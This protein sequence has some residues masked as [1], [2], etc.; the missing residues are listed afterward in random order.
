MPRF[1]TSGCSCDQRKPSAQRWMAW[2]VSCF[3]HSRASSF[4]R[5]VSARGPASAGAAA[6]A[7]TTG[8]G[9]GAAATG[10]G[11]AAAGFAAGA[12]SAAGFAAGAVS[13]A[14]LAAAV[15]SAAGF[16]AGVASAAFAASGALPAAA[17]SAGLAGGAS[18]CEAG[19]AAGGLALITIG[20]GG[21]GPMNM[22]QA[23][24]PATPSTAIPAAAMPAFF[25][26]RLIAIAVS[27]IVVLLNRLSGFQDT[28]KPPYAAL[29]SR[30]AAPSPCVRR[31]R[32][33]APRSA[34]VCP[35][36]LPAHRAVPCRKDGQYR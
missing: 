10:A 12:A 2:L 21:G 11:A 4:E 18:A 7:T 16:A 19:L 22:S 31:P 33:S 26:S 6:V 30:R 36:L 28:S 9:D 27:L 8:A 3:R 14:G 17:A 32:P 25:L 23:S 35:P 24:H 34:P 15:V 20:G 5:A 29:S 13:F 1:F